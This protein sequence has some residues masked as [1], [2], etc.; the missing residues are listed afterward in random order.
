MGPAPV[1]ASGGVEMESDKDETIVSLKKFRE[2]F[3]VVVREVLQ[4]ARS[5]DSSLL[6]VYRTDLLIELTL[7]THNFITRFVC[8]SN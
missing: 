3:K 6:S 5:H 8:M 4:A 1:M 7:T 2:N